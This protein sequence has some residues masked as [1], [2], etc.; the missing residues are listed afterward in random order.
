MTE[1][2]RLTIQLRIQQ[3]RIHIQNILKDRAI[4]I[5]RKTDMQ[6]VTRSGNIWKIVQEYLKNMD[7]KWAKPK[8]KKRTNS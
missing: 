8:F 4:K 1:K 3:E 6:G 5:K 7:K 2:M